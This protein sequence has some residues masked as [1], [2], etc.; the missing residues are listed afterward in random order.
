MGRGIYAFCIIIMNFKVHAEVVSSGVLLGAVKAT[1]A[2]VGTLF[3]PLTSIKNGI[4]TI[5]EPIKMMN[6]GMQAVQKET[7]EASSLL[8]QID[9]L[10]GGH[11]KGKGIFKSISAFN[12]TIRPYKNLFSGLSNERRDK[13]GILNRFA[14]KKGGKNHSAQI[15]ASQHLY[16]QVM[17][18]VTT[19]SFGRPAINAR[20]KTRVVQARR[21]LYRNANFDGSAI[22]AAQKQE[23]A[24]AYEHTKA[25]SESMEDRHST[26]EQ[27]IAIKKLMEQVVLELQ[28]L[29]LINAQQLAVQSASN[30][31]TED[32]N[33]EDLEKEDQVESIAEDAT[34]ES[35]E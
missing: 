5:T 6:S 14:V 31:N 4:G 8:R 7:R 24:K 34:S 9:K 19:D 21:R 18:K 16:K 26:L 17:P 32:V 1:T 30:M 11:L 15:R 29:R 20:E 23:L 12:G 25:I 10:T 28:Q 2:K 33:I 3:A 35:E 27:M 22:A 13:M